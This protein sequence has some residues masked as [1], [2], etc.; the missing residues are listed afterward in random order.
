MDTVH[1]T[2]VYMENNSSA[3]HTYNHLCDKNLKFSMNFNKQLKNLP[4]YDLNHQMFITVLPIQ[5]QAYKLSIIK[6]VK[7]LPLDLE[8]VSDS[9]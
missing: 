1:F 4:S 7:N 8:I 6:S 9:S 2:T 5:K 3:L